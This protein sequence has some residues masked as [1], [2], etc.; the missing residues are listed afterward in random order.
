MR[1]DLGPGELRG[2][3]PSAVLL[4]F[5]TFYIAPPALYL[6]AVV[7]VCGFNSECSVT[8]V[9]KKQIVPR[10]QTMTRFAIFAHPLPQEGV[11]GSTPLLESGRCHPTY[12]R[13]K[14]GGLSWL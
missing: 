10:T 3:A 14:D 6:I 1:R 9:V 4:L 8:S 2:A 12:P 13:T 5:E 11:E 7:A